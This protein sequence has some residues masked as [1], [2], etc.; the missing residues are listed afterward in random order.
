MTRTGSLLRS[1]PE[2]NAG[3]GFP[4]DELASLPGNLAN[5]VRFRSRFRLATAGPAAG[6]QVD[7][8]PVGI[9]RGQG[10]TACWKGWRGGSREGCLGNGGDLGEQFFHRPSHHCHHPNVPPTL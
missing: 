10:G 2:G 3:L 9:S 1:F 6:G 8:R 4:P 5:R 7:G